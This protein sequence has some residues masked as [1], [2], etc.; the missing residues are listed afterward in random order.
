MS[1]PKRISPMLDQ[2]LIGDAIS[3][4]SGVCAYPAMHQD[5]ND[6]YI[7]KVVTEPSSPTKLDA[8]LLTGAYTDESAALA[9]FK[10]LAQSIVDEAATLNKLAEYGGFLPFEDYQ[11]A[12]FPDT[13]GYHAYLLSRYQRTLARQMTIEPLTHL[14]AANLALDI[15][16]ALTVARK[17]GYLYTNLKPENIY[18][19]SEGEYKIGDLGLV[20]LDS[21]RYA[22]LPEKYRSAYTAPETSDAFAQLNETMDTYALGVILYRVYNNGLLPEITDSSITAPQNADYEMSEIILKACAVNPEDRWQSPTDM[23]QAIV[24][25][26]QRNGINDTPIAPP[27]VQ[28]SDISAETEAIDEIVEKAIDESVADIGTSEEAES[29]VAEAADVVAAEDDIIVDALS[30]ENIES[31][32]NSNLIPVDEIVENLTF[33]DDIYPDEGDL[34][35]EELDYDKISDEVSDI[36]EQAD[37]LAALEVPDPVVAPEA[38]EITIPDAV[39]ETSEE[40]DTSF[41][42]KTVAVLITDEEDKAEEISDTAAPATEETESESEAPKKKSHWVRN[43]IIIILVLALLAGAAYMFLRYY[44][45]PIDGIRVE[46]EEDRLTVYVDSRIDDSLLEVVCSDSSHGTPITAPVMGGKAVF[47]GLRDNTG[48]NVKIVV[49]GFHRLT[50]ESTTAYS[51]PVQTNILQFNA[52]TG[53]SAGSMILSFS[54]KGPDSDEWTISY[55]AEGEERQSVTFPSQMVTLE[56]L[57]VGKEYTFELSPVE[58]LYVDGQMTITAVASDLIFAENLFI[59]D[60][61]NNKLTANWS[62]PADAPEIESW[63]VRCYN[64]SGYNQSLV[65]EDTSV[66]FEGID[67]SASFNIE[68]IASGMSVGARTYVAENSICITNVSAVANADKLELTWDSSVE[69]P[70]SGWIVSYKVDGFDVTNPIYCNENKATIPNYV[71]GATYV[72][73][74]QTSAGDNFVGMPYAYKAESAKDFTITYNN[75]TVSA[76]D[77]EFS[78]CKA[79]N[80][81]NWNRFW[82]RSSD[83]RTT[84]S[85]DERIGF[86]VHMT[87]SYGNSYETYVN[88]FVVRDADGNIVAIDSV[89]D[90]WDGMWTRSYCVLTLPTTPSK[91]GNYTVDVFFNGAL[92]GSG[93]FTI[94]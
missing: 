68:V 65:T 22:V 94:Q 5:T 24:S 71:P 44:L 4:H 67:C 34:N 91:A 27:A 66:T 62:A 81:T 52:V 86:V 85:A 20:R 92:A 2:L 72:I 23:G 76:D 42:D 88:T 54:V 21:L 45:L 11:L 1:E 3:E 25:Y 31:D 53:S 35:E 37:D 83:Y 39:E 18:I 77:M 30:E 78:L 74:I 60:C 16:A 93:E 46:G 87:K 28:V 10:D 32:D 14:A 82:L 73:S 59:T 13:F 19:T 70:S 43:S 49:K 8:L 58:E 57:T 75:M 64:D 90:D 50:G 7:L 36:L 9:Y 41:E 80:A 15:C 63:T 55:W 17:S 40:A 26:M 89:T 84:F 61:S 79:P 12:E 33:L 51:T 47:V 48:Y 56:D 69:I 38:V 29:A 6:K